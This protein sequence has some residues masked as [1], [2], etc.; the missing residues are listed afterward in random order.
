MRYATHMTWQWGKEGERASISSQDEPK[1]PRAEW[2]IHGCL[3]I[4]VDTKFGGEY[5]LP[6]KLM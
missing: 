6:F 4:T 2:A 3:I 1:P 5:T